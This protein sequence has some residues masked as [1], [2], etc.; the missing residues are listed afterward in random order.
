M[1]AIEQNGRFPGEN[2]EGAEVDGPMPGQVAEQLA[3]VF[4][5]QIDHVVI[6]E[7]MQPGARESLE[8][9]P[10]FGGVG[11]IG[12]AINVVDPVTQIEHQV[13]VQACGHA[14]EILDHRADVE[15]SRPSPR[16]VDVGDDRNPHAHA[17]CRVA[18]WP[19][20]ACR[21]GEIVQ[22]VIIFILR[23]SPLRE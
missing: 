5:G 21:G 12:R 8:D 9:P 23:T 6:A 18:V 11:Q 16:E 3:V 15:R 10:K 4:S 7:E 22:L 13:G 20:N 1:P 17:P 14:D 19:A 2:A